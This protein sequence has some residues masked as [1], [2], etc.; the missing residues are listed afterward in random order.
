MCPLNDFRNV[1]NVSILG[2]SRAFQ[3][4]IYIMQV[5]A[6]LSTIIC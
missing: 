1:E 2:E 4:E 3:Q 6:P 5:E